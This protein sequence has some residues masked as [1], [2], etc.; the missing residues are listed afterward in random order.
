MQLIGL[1]HFTDP[2]VIL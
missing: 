2:V 1:M